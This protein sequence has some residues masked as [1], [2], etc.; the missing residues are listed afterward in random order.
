MMRGTNSGL[1]QGNPPT[2]RRLALPGADFI[3]VDGDRIRSVQGYFDQKTF[4][5]QLGLQ[6]IVVPTA[7][8]P[9]MFG[10]RCAVQP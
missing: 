3:A 4:V 8:G 1:L 6:A 2:G 10:S 5:E 9:M 7:V